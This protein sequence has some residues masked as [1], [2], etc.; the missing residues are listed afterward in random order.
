MVWGAV[1]EETRALVTTPACNM[2]VCKAFI[3]WR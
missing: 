1:R 3:A 2:S